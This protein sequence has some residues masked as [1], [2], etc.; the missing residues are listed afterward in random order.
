MEFSTEFLT[1]HS[2]TGYKPQCHAQSPACPKN[3]REH[4]VQ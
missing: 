3:R 2:L 4:N 1:T